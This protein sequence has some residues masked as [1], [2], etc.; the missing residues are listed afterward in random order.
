M[1]IYLFNIL[2]I[3]IYRIFIKDKKFF[4]IAISFQMFL[5]MALRD[6]TIGA[7]LGN[8]A[9]GFQYIST[10]GFAELISKLRFIRTADLIYRY[11]YESGYVVLNWFVAKLGFSF[12]G[13]LVILAA[14]NMISF[15]TFIY[16]Y[17][18]IPWLS[19]VLLSG[20]NMYEYAFGIL[21]QSLAVSIVLWSVPYI[22]EKKRVK[23][24][25][26][27]LLAFMFHR[28]SVLFLPLLF[29]VEKPLTKKVFRYHMLV[30]ACMMA[31]TPILYEKV[32]GKI[33]K[34]IGK[35]RYAVVDFRL[36]NQILLML[37]IAIII[38]LFIDFRNFA[39][40]Q[41][42]LILWG[43]L[44]SIPVEIVGMCNDSFARSIEYYYI[45]V[46]LLIPAVIAGYQ[47]R[48]YYESDGKLSYFS[49]KWSAAI[50][51]FATVS[52]VLLVVLL[53]VYNLSDSLLIPYKLYF[54]KI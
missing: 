3:P 31:V 50:R 37:A 52:V 38:Y 54:G 18:K 43:Y 33:L 14:F 21:R 48:G 5:I 46:I 9:D 13:F 36:N 25:L 27:I 12:H 22:L 15:G 10:L 30:W 11:S 19:F 28:T 2:S 29:F 1:G 4:T 20:L 41:E 44:L 7:D 24:C 53:M 26:T 6:V 47:F 49:I 8:Y 34:L 51:L 16:R 23:T 32:L 40:R 35:G 39:S 45:F 42:G 17:S